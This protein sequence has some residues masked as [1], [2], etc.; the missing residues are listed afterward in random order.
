MEQ[1]IASDAPS[2]EAAADR[3]AASGDRA[4]ART[5]LVRATRADP[6]RAETWV[7]LA[8]MCR[9]EGDIEAALDAVSGA[10]KIDPLGF[11]P[12]LLKAS[13]LEKA[14]RAAEAGETYGYALAQAPATL[15]PH[16][17]AMAAHARTRHDAHVAETAGRLARALEEMPLSE[18]EQRRLARFRSNIVRTTRPYHSEPTHFHYPGLREREYHDRALFPWL[19]EL[20]AATAAIREDFHRVMAGERAELVPYIQ[21]PDDV[22]LRQWAELNR[23][24][25]WTA[26]HLV[27]N[28]VTIEANARHCPSVMAMLGDMEQPEIP[29]RGPNAMFSLL[30]PGAHIPPHVGV[31]NTRL[32]CHLP[33]IVPAGCWFRVGA[34]TR[35]WEEGKAW[36]FDDTIEHEA[37]NPTSELRVILIIDT[38]H[39]DLGPAERAAVAAVMSATDT[40]DVLEGL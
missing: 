20:E 17:E 27:Q 7:K 39:P 4:G 25:A 9:A 16:L 21:Y 13:L 3:A 1:E 29:R 24:R 10:L 38:W 18:A 19:A 35:L 30:A 28:G 11:L 26:I 6:D 37:M 15:P 34:E 31:A 40:D 36:V 5:L 32:V 2:L 33:L 22:P 23:N 12:L 14:G 8:A